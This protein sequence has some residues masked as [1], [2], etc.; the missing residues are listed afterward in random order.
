LTHASNIKRWEEFTAS[1]AA[2]AGDLPHLEIQRADLGKVLQE[3]LEIL[4]QQALHRSSKQQSSKT[5]ADLMTEGERLTRV[6]ELSL[7]HHYGPESEK[8]AEFGMPAVP[9]RKRKAT[10]AAKP[11]PQSPEGTPSPAD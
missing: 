3:A 1:L 7:S 6:L 4:S 10:N 5:P 9:R 8:L 2:N 11:A